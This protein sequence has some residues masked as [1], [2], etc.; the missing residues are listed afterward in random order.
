[1]IRAGLY[2]IQNNLKLPS[3]IDENL[4]KADVSRTAGLQ[5]LPETRTEAIA[6]ARADTFIRSCIPEKILE[7]YCR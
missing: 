7:I 3:P 1:M 5:K 2:G 4:Y 6:A